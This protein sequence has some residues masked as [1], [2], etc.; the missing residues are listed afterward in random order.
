MSDLR[1]RHRGK[2]ARWQDVDSA[3]ANVARCGIGAL[4]LLSR[5]FL[6]LTLSIV[7]APIAKADC[8]D[9]FG[10]TA[11]NAFRLN[12]LLDGPNCEFLYVMRNGIYAE[13]GYCFRTP[14]AISTFGADHCH[15]ADVGQLGLNRLEQA[16]AAT[17]L[18][19]EHIKGCPE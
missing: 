16:N 7:A 8:Y 2:P 1:L 9:V 12:D 14:R 11:Q 13:H 6:A 5:L 15:V 17:I 18:H 19:A 3:A 10:C 4:M